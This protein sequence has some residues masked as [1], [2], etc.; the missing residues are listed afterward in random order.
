L[1][2]RLCVF[3]AVIAAD[4]WFEYDGDKTKYM[5]SDL[6]VSLVKAGMPHL[7]TGIIWEK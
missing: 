3:A 4:D 6:G 2:E 7:E 5:H 1:G